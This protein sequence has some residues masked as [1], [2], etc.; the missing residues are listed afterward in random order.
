MQMPS[1]MP[2]RDAFGDA[3]D[4]GL[5]AGVFDGPPLPC[6]TGAGLDLVGDEEDAVAIA[7]AANLLEEVV[8]RDDVAAFALDGLE[9]DGG[10]LFG[11]EDGFEETVFDVAGA[12]EGEGLLLGGA[13]GGAAVGVGVADVGDA[14]DEGRE[15]ALLLRL[16]AGERECA[17]G[18]AMEAAKEADDVLAAGLVAGEFHGALDSLGAGVAEVEAVRAGHRR[19][20]GET[21]GDARH[22]VVEEIG[23]GDVDEFGGLVLNCLHYFGMT[24]ACRVD[25]NAGGEVEELVAVDVGDA[26][27][28]AGFGHHGIA[29]GIAGRDEALIVGNDLFCE[30][31]GK[32]GLQFGAEL[33]VVCGAGVTGFVGQGAHGGSPSESDG[34]AVRWCAVR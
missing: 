12:V 32:R 24:V 19:H 17:H 33:A 29:A 34:S 3:D 23:A 1:G 28:A 27:A 6:S 22:V 15:A 26:E 21:L 4:V 11:R 9:D 31:A 5:D 16:G 10:D 8:G 30:R 18:A 13:A 2:R 14:G 20:G 25:R 7:D